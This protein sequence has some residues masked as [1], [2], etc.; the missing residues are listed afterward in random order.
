[1]LNIN[2]LYQQMRKNIALCYT[3]TLHINPT[4]CDDEKRC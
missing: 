3:Q 1:M 4:K 2:A